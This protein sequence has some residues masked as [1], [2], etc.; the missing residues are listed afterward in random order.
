M[1]KQRTPE[2][3][4]PRDSA[5]EQ[6]PSAEHV[7]SDP[8]ILIEGG[9]VINDPGL[10][11][12]DLDLMDADIV[13]DG[14]PERARKLAAEARQFGLD[15][16]PA[17]FDAFADTADAEI[18]QF[19]LEQTI[20]KVVTDGIDTARRNGTEI[21]TGTAVVIA[22]GLAR[23]LDR[24][25][26]A[27]ERFARSGDGDPAELRD[28]YLEL[29]NAPSTP[30]LARV[31]IDWLG[32][33]IT[34][35][36]QATPAEVRTEPWWLLQS[37]KMLILTLTNG[38]GSEY[39]H[40]LAVVQKREVDI[41]GVAVELGHLGT[42]HDLTEQQ[43]GWIDWLTRYLVHGDTDLQRPEGDDGAA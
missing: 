12:I 42:R 35:R 33:Y 1:E 26:S 13:I 9:L 8:Y 32:T 34:H 3:E 10:P 41:G 16:I 30:R 6:Q 24:P 40:L 18:A 23:A 15:D 28:E 20:E 4:Q 5:G 36:P 14:D 27:L 29:Y 21:D 2:P 17:R 25:G 11:I 39:P 37:A 31:W 38:D 19:R 43:R 7:G 22:L